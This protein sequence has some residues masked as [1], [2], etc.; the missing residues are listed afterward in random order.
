MRK[1]ESPLNSKYKPFLGNH[2]GQVA[3]WLVLIGMVIVLTFAL[4]NLFVYRTFNEI[5]TD[6]QADTTFNNESKVVMQ[7]MND[8]FPL[9]FDALTLVIIVGFFLFSLV[10][11]YFS[12]SHP[13]LIPVFFIIA[14]VLCIV[15][16]ILSNTWNEIVMEDDLAT[17]IT[18]FPITNWILNNYLLVIGAGMF[19]AL[20]T[21]FMRQ[22]Y[23]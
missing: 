21:M 18:S 15:A 4:I 16:M 22:R 8:R 6:F 17:T 9:T 12:D 23:T 19:T 14:I 3:L 13:A 11:G 10:A 20:I 2:K 1:Q 7:D 5:N